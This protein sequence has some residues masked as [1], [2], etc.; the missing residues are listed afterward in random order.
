MVVC[1]PDGYILQIEGLYFADHGNN[2]ATILRSMLRKE[3]SI[4]SVVQSGDAT[5]L[6][7][8]FRDSIP[9][10]E[11]RG[12][13]TFMPS[14]FAK[15][16]PDGTKKH[17]FTTEEANSS[18]RVTLL[19]R[20]VEQV[21]GRI[22]NKFHFFEQTIRA[23]HFKKLNEYLRVCVSILNAFSPPLFTETEFHEKVASQVEEH[24]SDENELMQRVINENWGSKRALWFKV[25]VDCCLT[26][27]LLSMEELEELMLGTYQLEI[28][29]RYND[30]HLVNT[31]VY[32]FFYYKDEP[33][34]IRVKLQSRHAKRVK[35]TVWIE[36]KESVNCKEGIV[37]WYCQC[38]TGSRTL[39]SCAHIAA[40]SQ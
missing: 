2:D 21:N 26:F 38:K 7:R 4:L 3:D 16:N 40:V 37:G 9:D 18:R 5:I 13:L 1:F 36:F 28:G 30:M 27:P 33:T 24:F 22:K 11:A 10:L 19:R 25:D 20:I 8:G 34:I 6:D 39:G 15:T 14:F 12:I 17:Q 23:T 35:Y 31:G 29:I 32:E